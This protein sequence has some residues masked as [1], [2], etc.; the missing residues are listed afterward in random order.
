MIGVAAYL[1]WP[2]KPVTG[3]VWALDEIGD[4]AFKEYMLTT[5]WPRC[6][7]YKPSGALYRQC[8][9]EAADE[10]KEAYKGQDG[11]D[12]EASCQALGSR[13]EGL[14]AGEMTL[15]CEAYRYS[16]NPYKSGVAILKTAYSA[17]V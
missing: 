10:A 14:L 3:E 13:F 1:M 11:S 7:F 6:P 15:S 2:A 4:P 12:I 16:K 5:L 8:L 17:G 9:Q